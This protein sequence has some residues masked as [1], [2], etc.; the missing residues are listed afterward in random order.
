MY[1]CT[2]CSAGC[3]SNA[4]VQMKQDLATE[5]LPCLRQKYMRRV[6][7][8][9]AWGVYIA[10]LRASA[11]AVAVAAAAAAA[12]AVAAALAA[13]A[14]QQA[15]GHHEECGKGQATNSACHLVESLAGALA[16]TRQSED[17][18]ARC[19]MLSTVTT[20]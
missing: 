17:T 20:P 5:G 4:V 2:P 16:F 11:A 9:M 19:V 18:H 12:A 10:S 15:A 1:Y 13:A 8:A 14:L 6:R 7:T 3:E